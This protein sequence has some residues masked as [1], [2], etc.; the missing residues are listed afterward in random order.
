MLQKFMPKTIAMQAYLVITVVVTL[1]M[2][3]IGCLYADETQHH[4]FLSQAW[5]SVFFIL[6][7]AWLA[8][9]LILNKVFIDIDKTLSEVADKI[10][11]Q[12]DNADIRKV[13]QL[14]PVLMAVKTL[15]SSL[16][17]KET[18]HRTLVEN[19]PDM[20]MRHDV[21]GKIIYGNPV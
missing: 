10:A 13:P 11:R 21:M 5:F 8:L 7:I 2:I 16:Q 18:V 12:D 9:V 19:S 17:E 4:I 20:I 14:R 1:L 3:V 6:F 15:R